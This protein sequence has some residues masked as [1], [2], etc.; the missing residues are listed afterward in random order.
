MRTV[1]RRKLFQQC[2]DQVTELFSKPTG[3][4]R[5]GYQHGRAGMKRHERRSLARAFAAK[6]WRDGSPERGLK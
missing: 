4:D 1:E 2:F 3:V 6:M 5:Y